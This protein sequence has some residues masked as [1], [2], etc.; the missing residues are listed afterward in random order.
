MRNISWLKGA[1]FFLL[2]INIPHYIG[3]TGVGAVV[4]EVAFRFVSL[5]KLLKTFL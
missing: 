4:R 2:F 3:E 1:Y 5:R